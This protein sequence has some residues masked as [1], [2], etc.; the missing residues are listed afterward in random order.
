MDFIN[1]MPEPTLAE[2]LRA[3]KARSIAQS[4]ATANKEK[5][6]R[7]Q[8]N[9]QLQKQQQENN[10][11]YQKHQEDV[12]E[13]EKQ[14]AD[15]E[16]AVQQLETEQKA[17]AAK[18]QAA[19]ETEQKRISQ[20]KAIHDKYDAQISALG[21]KPLKYYY[22]PKYYTDRTGRTRQIGTTRESNH[23]VIKNYNSK[24]DTI[25]R[26][27][28]AELTNFEIAYSDI[29]ATF[30]ASARREASKSS[31]V[32]I[33]ARAQQKWTAH[34]SE[35][36]RIRESSITTARS[37]AVLARE[38]HEKTIREYEAKK[39]STPVIPS[40]IEKPLLKATKV[41]P[42]VHPS[43]Y[44]KSTEKT[45]V[46]IFGTTM[47]QSQK[48]EETYDN[49][50]AQQKELFSDVTGATNYKQAISFREKAQEKNPYVGTAN[51]VYYKGDAIGSSGVLI[52]K[53]LHEDSIPDD[54]FEELAKPTSPKPRRDSTTRQMGSNR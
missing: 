37:N 36:E 6:Q 8:Q 49:T 5:Q 20:Q 35:S 53:K 13:Y 23:N 34:L 39:D 2:K 1:T 32:N 15:Y 10:A 38:E 47:V 30:I 24:V 42:K 16:K 44:F 22:K 43:S 52:E 54:I 26:S 50:Q 48:A 3:N 31:G 4:D 7:I 19:K 27:R 11:A 40:I 9:I 51:T 14:K 12:I 21:A 33:L 46:S 45:P 28:S 41:K 29:P 25:N 17:E 18:I